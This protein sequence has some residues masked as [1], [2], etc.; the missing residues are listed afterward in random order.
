MVVI[1]LTGFENESFQNES[2]RNKRSRSGQ[3]Q[4]YSF[5]RQR[6]ETT[7]GS[8]FITIIDHD[9]DPVWCADHGDDNNGGYNHCR[10][11]LLSSSKPRRER[12]IIHTSIMQ[13]SG[14][15]RA[16]CIST[17]FPRPGGM[18]THSCSL[19]FIEHDHDPVRCA[20][21]GDDNDGGHNHSGTSLSPSSK[22]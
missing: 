14:Q 22:P 17:P 20:D 13:A 2:F 12:I 9:H 5:P 21:H 3:H 11:S 4:M 1:V 19:P 16:T 15:Q 18:T 6:D 7:T 10:M 8:L